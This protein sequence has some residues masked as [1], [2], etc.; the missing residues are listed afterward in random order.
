MVCSNSVLYM[1]LKVVIYGEWIV[2]MYITAIGHAH[3]MGVSDSIRAKYTKINMLG[4][5]IKL[6]ENTSLSL[7]RRM[8]QNVSACHILIL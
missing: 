5:H 6:T 2:Y 8:A 3:F 1:C 4:Q 7:S